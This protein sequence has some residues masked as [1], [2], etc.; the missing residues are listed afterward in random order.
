MTGLAD[1]EDN[2]ALRPLRAQW[3]DHALAVITEVPA[4]VL[5]A[6]EIVVLFAGVVSRYVFH[7]PLT[8]SDELASILF[9]WLAMFGAVIALRRG[10]HMRLTTFVNRVAPARRALLETIAAMAVVVFVLLILVPGWDY[11]EDEWAILTPALEI[12][13]SFRAAAIEVGAVLMM[14]IALARLIERASLRHVAAA[15]AVAAF[16]AVALWLAR[17]ML[18]A[19]GNYNLLVFFVALVA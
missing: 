9:L 7:Q 1:L 5:V 11:V 2:G 8:W 12:H 10:E 19:L 3:L 18:I 16:L 6:L 13:N 17:P 14:V 4:A 15:L